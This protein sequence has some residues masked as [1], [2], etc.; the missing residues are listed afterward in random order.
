[1]AAK[2]EF[3]GADMVKKTARKGP[4]AGNQFWGCSDWSPK[5]K[6]S[7]WDL[8]DEDGSSSSAADS[9]PSGTS[10]STAKTPRRKTNP[11]ASELAL[12]PEKV[13]WSD[14]ADQRDDWESR[15]TSAGARIRSLPLSMVE[16]VGVK[17]KLLMNF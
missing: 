11:V 6:H 9:E 1:M 7:S 15:Y 13:L 5:G 3:C 14:L 10:N 2:C 8:E 12:R 16:E 4:N 17:Q